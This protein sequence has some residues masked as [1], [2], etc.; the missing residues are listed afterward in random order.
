[1]TSKTWDDPVFA[2]NAYYY[3]QGNRLI[4]PSGIVNWPFYCSSI[5]A[6]A[7]N[8]GA[9]GAVIGHEITHAFD[10]DGM[11]YDS[12]G[13]IHQ[14]WT[15]N[16]YKEYI[17]KTKAIINLFNKGIHFNHKVNGKL[18]LSENISD[19]GGIAISL[20]AL[21]KSQIE[22][23]LNNDDI[24]NE[25]KIFFI[26]YAVSWRIKERRKKAIQS[27]FIDRHA[28]SHLRVNYIVNNFD[29]WYLAFNIQP[30]NKLYIPPE[31]RIII[32]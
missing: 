30:K 29:E 9:L 20:D 7:W 19:L 24:I 23:K 22:R 26:S 12:E 5:K 16:D 6:I 14:W 27:L 25:L 32:F 2:V 8:Y 4:L 21:K 31:E 3:N 17:K 10:V 15:Q 13:K 18:T 11:I 1:M 28:P